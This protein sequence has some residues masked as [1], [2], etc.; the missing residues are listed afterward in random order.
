[1]EQTLSK[2]LFYSTVL[3]NI[4]EHYDK[5]LFGLVAPFIAPLYFP[6][7]DPIVA[8]ILIYLPM[9]LIARPFGALYW[10]RIGDK[11]GRK[12]VLFLSLL[13]MSL[14][15][16]FTGLLP[17]YPSLG[18]M[19]ACLLHLS[20]G[21]TCFFAAGEGVSAAL[22]LIENT[23]T[24]TKD[25]MCSYYEMSSMLGILLAS[26]LVTWLCFHNVVLSY[27]RHL[28]IVSGL[29]G[30]IGVWVRKQTFIEKETITKINKSSDSLMTL[31][32]INRAPLIAIVLVTG[33][34]CANYNILTQMMNSYIP[35]VSSI[36]STEMMATHCILISVDFLLLPIFGLLS[37]KIGKEKLILF[38]LLCAMT[39]V[40]PLF[41]LLKTPTLNRVLSIRT[42]LVLW[43]I[44][45][46]APFNYWAIS[47][48][49]KA[50]RFR[51]ISLARAIGA[52]G[53]GGFSISFSL[54][55]F[56]KTNWAISP[57]IVLFLSATAS[58]LSVALL[59]KSKNISKNKKI[60]LN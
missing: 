23:K 27:W 31:L 44:A 10:G 14:T 45:I 56:H 52:Q 8:L 24:K 19:S 17:T 29:I 12:R 51:I 53:I 22:V 34:L 6:S 13:G 16:L 48:V 25:L 5:V 58:A 38:A 35:L 9:G 41:N 37:K 4:L 2:K 57:A 40:F 55:I 33:F 11:M 20:R 26:C 21:L 49:Q 43:G 32:K 50:N 7:S 3:G 46:T 42:L 47:L 1:M 28:F 59:I 36:S 39:L 18:I 30:L 15:M 60:T 54:F